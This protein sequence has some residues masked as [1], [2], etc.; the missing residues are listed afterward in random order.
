[1]REREREEDTVSISVC[2]H[3]VQEAKPRADTTNTIF[4]LKK[5]QVQKRVNQ[6]NQTEKKRVSTHCNLQTAQ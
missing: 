5:I 1:M 3:F 2:L 6:S 4:I